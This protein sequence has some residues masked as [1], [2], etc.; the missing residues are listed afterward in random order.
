MVSVVAD[1]GA[2][3]GA[4]TDQALVFRGVPFAQA[5]RFGPPRPP[6]PWTGVRDSTQPGPAAPQPDRGAGRFTHGVL[7][8]T[9]EYACLSLNVFTPSL[10]GA[11]PVFVWIHGGGFAVGHPS[12][13]IYDAG[14]LAREADAVVVTVGYRLGSLG[15]VAHPDLAAGSGEPAGNWGLLDQIEA[16]RWVNRNIA[17]FGGDPS[18]VTLGGQSAGG[19][20]A[21]DILAATSTD[22]LVHRLIAQSP[23]L[24]DLVQSVEAGVRWAQALHGMLGGDGAFDADTVRAAPVADILAAHEKLLETSEF[25]GTRGAIPTLD[26]GSLPV[27][28]LESPGEA[29]SVPILIGSTADEG[30]FFFNSPWRPSPPAE[31]IPAVVAHLV[32]GEDPDAVLAR[33]RAIAIERGAP[34]DPLHLLVAIA[35]EAMV[36]AP[37]R[38]FARARARGVTGVAAAG[39]SVGGARCGA[40]HRYRVDH[41]G[42]GTE[43]GATHTVEVPLLFGTWNDG[44]PGSQLGGRGPGTEDV[45]TRLVQAWRA[46]IHGRDPGWRAIGSDGAGEVGVF[47]GAAP[48]AITAA[49]R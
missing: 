9:D 44:G 17:A 49:D 11:A 13:S 24:G 25:R 18:R 43:L 8:A 7:P 4:R 40:V 1:C 5:A 29:P 41:P 34:S 19:L 31:R 23:P 36:A 3:R 20:S 14:A 12:S 42:G 32:P 30:T 35:T 46:F 38:S 47:G 45:A 26:P 48:F 22:G 37:V 28:L 10:D 21:L 27:S 6:A 15:W 33:Q 2:L 16:L 39:D